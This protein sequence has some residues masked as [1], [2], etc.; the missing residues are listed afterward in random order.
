MAKVHIKIVLFLLLLILPAL[1]AKGGSAMKLTSP[2]FKHN[3]F[4]PDKFTCDGEDVN[5]ELIIEDIPKEAKSLVLIL[6]DPDASVGTWVHWI[7]FNIPVINRI[8]E[9]SIPGKQGS[10][11]SGKRDYRGPRPPLGT[12]RYF[13]KVYA[14]DTMLNLQEGIAKSALLDAMQGHILANAELIG[15][16]R[17]K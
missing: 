12:H 10:N 4:I 5:P 16:Y 8:E 3:Q 6:D 13:F 1:E 17:R 2:E 11:S 14:L 9:N 15:L 7:V